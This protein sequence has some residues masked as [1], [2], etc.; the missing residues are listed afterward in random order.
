M[1]LL[2]LFKDVISPI[3]G[4]IDALHTSEDEKLRA[5]AG[6]LTIQAAL[7]EKIVEYEGRLADAQAKVITAEAQGASSLQ[8]NWRPILMLTFTAIVAW[9]YIVVPI[10]GAAPAL[11]PE[12]MWTLMQIGVGGYVLGRSGEKIVPAV[13]AALKEK[14]K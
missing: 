7:T 11:V 10:V 8:R 4:L 9:N 6:L 12:Q 14:D 13:V 3:T 2:D 1:G 5:K